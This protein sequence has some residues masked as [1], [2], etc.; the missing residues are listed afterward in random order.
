MH[1]SASNLENLHQRF[2]RKNVSFSG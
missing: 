2:E 1:F